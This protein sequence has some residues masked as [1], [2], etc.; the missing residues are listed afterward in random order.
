[1]VHLN[2]LGIEACFRSLQEDAF[3][4]IVTLERRLCKADTGISVY[5]SLALPD[6]VLVLDRYIYCTLSCLVI[7]LCRSA[8]D[9]PLVV[10]TG[11]DLTNSSALMDRS[12][13]RQCR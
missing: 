8:L 4:M 7:M 12:N 10:S 5:G 9:T 3:T 11:D 1:M 13:L 2:I 6:L